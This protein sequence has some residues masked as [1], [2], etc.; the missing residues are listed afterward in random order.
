MRTLTLIS[1][2]VGWVV[3]GLGAVLVVLLGLV[4]PLLVQFNPETAMRYPVVFELAQEALAGRLWFPVIIIVSGFVIAHVAKDALD[5]PRRAPIWVGLTGVSLSFLVLGAT[6]FVFGI[7]V[8]RDRSSAGVISVNSVGSLAETM[9]PEQRL[10]ALKRVEAN[11][12]ESLARSRELGEEITRRLEAIETS[13][14][15]EASDT[16]S[17]LVATTLAQLHD[18]AANR[19]GFTSEKTIFQVT[20]SSI[21]RLQPPVWHRTRG[22]VIPSRVVTAE[23]ERGQHVQ[24]GDQEGFYASIDQTPHESYGFM[25]GGTGACNGTPIFNGEFELVQT[26][27]QDIR[28][29]RLEWTNDQFCAKFRFNPQTCE[30]LF[31]SQREY[32]SAY[33]DR[34][35]YFVIGRRDAERLNAVLKFSDG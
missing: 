16:A 20:S 25:K 30:I 27:I 33:R 5:S 15:P 32:R 14:S 29:Y 34:H 18:I 7:V 1:K 23:S 19:T 10:T 4:G 21:S 3:I 17:E 12:E 35:G 8:D 22:M 9:D 26:T 28:A 6:A 13:E 31:C 2:F 24:P 11:T